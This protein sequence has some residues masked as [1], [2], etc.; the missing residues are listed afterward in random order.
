MIK[1]ST[2]ACTIKLQYC[3]FMYQ[4]RIDVR[5][6]DISEQIK[7]K[8]DKLEIII[9]GLK[10]WYSPLCKLNFTFIVPISLAFTVLILKLIY[11]P[12]IEAVKDENANFNIAFLVIFCAFIVGWII[13]KIKNCLFPQVTFAIG[14]GVDRYTVNEK[15]RWIFISLLIS[16]ILGLIYKVKGLV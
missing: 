9:D 4:A 14:Q 5:L 6:V 15:I 16:A 2:S 7:I 1:L 8:K 12:T 10:P 11:L 13:D 3:Y